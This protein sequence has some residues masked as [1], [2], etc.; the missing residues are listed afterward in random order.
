MIRKKYLSIMLTSILAFLTCIW[1]T[2]LNAEEHKR[3]EADGK[4]GQDNFKVYKVDLSTQLQGKL[5]NKPVSAETPKDASGFAVVTHDIK[6]ATLAFYIGYSGLSGDGLIMAHFHSVDTNGNPIIQT[7]CGKPI[8]PGL[9][10]DWPKN[11]VDKNQRA[12]SGDCPVGNSGYLE[13]RWENVD[14]SYLEMLTSGKM[15]M[16]LHTQLNPKGE[17]DGYVLPLSQ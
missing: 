7:I 5:S 14:S 9:I 10:P 16:N 11:P 3:G 12:L 15:N 8:K 17:V 6:Q 13:G 2:G 1:G 4:A